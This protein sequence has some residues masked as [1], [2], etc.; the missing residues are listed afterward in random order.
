MTEET[1]PK[2][3][4]TI[5]PNLKVIVANGYYDLATL[6][7]ATIY[8]FNHHLSANRVN[9]KHPASRP[10]RLAADNL[11]DIIFLNMR[12]HLYHLRCQRDDLHKVLLT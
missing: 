7:F 2:E 10:L 12:G 9:T 3:E 5:N 4:M 8:T 11:N 1:K 6:Y